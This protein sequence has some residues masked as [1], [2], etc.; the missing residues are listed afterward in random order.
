MSDIRFSIITC[1][2]NSAH[3]L[4]NY[5]AALRALDVAGRRVEFIL[6]DN[7]SRDATPAGLQAGLAG[8][9][10]PA[11]I[12]AESRPGL[13]Y[14]RC[15]GLAAARGEFV[16]FLDDDNEP[17]PDYLAE[18]DRLIAAHPSAA[19]FTGNTV[20][21]SG[22]PVDAGNTGALPLLV[23][24]ELPGEFA[25]ILDT[26][27]S[28][29]FP[30]GAGLFARREAL[31]QACRAWLAG[32]SQAITGRAG[33]KLSGGEDIWLAHFLTRHGERVVFSDR[34]RLVHRMDPERLRPTYLGRLAFENGVEHAQLVAAIRML[35]PALP[36]S[37]TGR[38]GLAWAILVRLPWLALQCC[39]R[40][41]TTSFTRVASALGHAYGLL[42]AI[43]GGE[44]P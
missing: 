16:L 1:F 11:R 25:F 28:P 42:F 35:K 21:P 22:Y 24:R 36:A 27:H 9:G 13:M 40:R 2:F 44:K 34:L 23:V 38:N 20:L 19:M 17:A 7:A 39:R 6:V 33:G 31:G 26:F 41:D 5:F 14:A 12:L 30:W 3:R 32:G 8:L 43:A 18:L 15:T 37:R 10:A 29:H 4:E